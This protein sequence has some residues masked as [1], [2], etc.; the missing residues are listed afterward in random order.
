MTA[1]IAMGVL[2]YLN[3]RLT[4]VTILILGALTTTRWATET[5]RATADRFRD[6]PSGYA[7]GE[8]AA[9]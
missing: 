8:A 7:A 1:V 4:T 5:A 3:W 2:M 6:G 9:G